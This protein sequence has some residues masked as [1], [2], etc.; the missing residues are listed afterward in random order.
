MSPKGRTP[1][2][3]NWSLPSSLNVSPDE[4][5]VRV[6]FY[7]SSV[8]LQWLEN[9]A[10]STRMVSAREVALA[11]LSDIP[12]HSGLLPPDALWWSQDATAEVALWV[13]PRVWPVALMVKA[14]EPAPRFRLPMP[15]FIFV[16][17]PA[18]APRI[19]AVKRRPKSHK[20]EVYHAPLFNVFGD[21]RTCAGS[22]QYPVKIEDIPRSFFTSFFSLDG[23]MSGR[24]KKH[25]D[26]LYSLWQEL[27]GRKRYPL[28]DL[29][30]CGT[31]E[32]VMNRSAES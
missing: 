18:E 25:P 12:L 3:Y 1:M 26:S 9:G 23:S 20:D 19:Y 27:D 11:L 14:G 8:V 17:R 2:P 22:H 32:D 5:Q 21:G 15:G 6:D 24:S 10:I 13:R 31:V 7:N 16:C 29:V 30:P 4:L 28:G